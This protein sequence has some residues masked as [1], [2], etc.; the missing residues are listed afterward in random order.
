VR[1][2]DWWAARAKQNSQTKPTRFGQVRHR[3]VRIASMATVRGQRSQ[4][5]EVCVVLM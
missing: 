5:V 1:Q 4:V 3:S 2:R